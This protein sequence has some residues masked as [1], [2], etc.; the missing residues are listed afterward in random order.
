MWGG[1]EMTHLTGLRSLVNK[2]YVTVVVALVLVPS[3]AAG[4][5]LT[6]GEVF[7]QEEHIFDDLVPNLPEAMNKYDMDILAQ[8]EGAPAV[9]SFFD[10]FVELDTESKRAIAAKI[11]ALAE[12]IMAKGYAMS[13]LRIPRGQITS[14][15]EFMQNTPRFGDGVPGRRLPAELVQ[16]E[17]E[18][19]DGSVINSSNTNSVYQTE[20]AIL[21][22]AWDIKPED[23]SMAAMTIA[24]NAHDPGITLLQAHITNVYQLQPE[25]MRSIKGSATFN[26]EPMFF[27]HVA[28]PQLVIDPYGQSRI[29][30]VWWR[31]WWYDSHL[32]KNW[33]YGGYWWWWWYYQWSGAPWA[34]WYN[35]FWGWYHW[36][37]W[38]GWCNL[39]VP[40]VDS[41]VPPVPG[42]VP[43]PP[44]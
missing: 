10:V 13:G 39:W 26:K 22:V 18:G 44:G 14:F 11:D 30:V 41:T 2:R 40:P 17:L 7:S 34:W 6:N 32:H 8:A 36:N 16:L 38:W 23:G 19:I 42:G 1:W 24:L 9:D 20:I 25:Q 21:T 35:W 4:F 29:K 37:W 3:L 33:W 27:V 15:T 28:Q 12:E 43:P 5:L 31:Y